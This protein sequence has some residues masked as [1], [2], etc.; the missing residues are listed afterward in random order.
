M[1]YIDE[2]QMDTVQTW[3]LGGFMF[4]FAYDRYMD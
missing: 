2:Q 3:L 1:L 4:F